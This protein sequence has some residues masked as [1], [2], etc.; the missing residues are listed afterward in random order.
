ME[1]QAKGKFLRIAPRKARTVVDMIR[2]R[3]ASEASE[4]L[5]FTPRSGARIVGKLLHSAVS[6]AQQQSAGIDVDSLYVK[7]VTVDE[8][9]TKF[10]RRWRP[11][12]MG[13]AT[14]IIKRTSHITIVLENRS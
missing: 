2:G 8:G 13:R 5:R 14:R 1:V 11:R 6:N 10:M 4:L 7:T 12:A 9:P 3:N